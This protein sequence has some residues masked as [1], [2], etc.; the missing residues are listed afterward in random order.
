[1]SNDIY[2]CTPR[3][4]KA[5]A[6]DAIEAGLVPFI[7]SS[8]GMG[9]SSI[10]REIARQFRLWLIDHRLSTSAPEDL[11][12]L[13][14]FYTD[15]SGI[16]RARFVPFEMFPVEGTKLPEGYDG[17]MVFLDEANSGTKMVQAASYKLILDRMV[18]QYK[19]HERVAMAMAGN[20]ST[21]RAITT[22]LSTAMQSRVIH[23][24][25]IVDFNEWLED[26]ALPQQYDE[27]VI[28]FFNWKKDY[29]MDFRPDHQEKTFTCPRTVEFLNRL[30]KGKEITDE[31]TPLY[32]G[33]VTSGVAAEFVQFSKIFKEMTQ[34]ADVLRD[35]ANADV[36]HES[37]RKW[38]V[39]SHLM[40]ETTPQNFDKICIYV[41]KFDLAF[42]V[43]YFR[44]ILHKH[45]ALRQSPIFGK[46]ILDITKYLEGN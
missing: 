22:S 37:Q 24:E 26:V 42:R 16:R 32:A 2:R 31:K 45:P 33:T 43:L 8:P 21:D 14:E 40:G 13:P 4:A 38:A 41:N 35:P 34:I 6:I 29:L 25:M 15:E 46:A 11:S 19:L 23:I 28:A 20:L 44:G 27:R 18:G 9:K 1:M 10:M 36:P 5:L 30:V 17:W 7:Q 12:G 3:Q 39:I